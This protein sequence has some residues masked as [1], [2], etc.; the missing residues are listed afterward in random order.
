MDFTINRNKNYISFLANGK[1][2]P[3][4][5]D[6]NTGILYSMQSKPLK[7]LPPKFK[8]CV[9]QY[10]E[11]NNIVFTL[12]DRIIQE[13]YNYGDDWS[14]NMS[15]FTNHAELF[16]IA[17][18]LN[19]L[20]YVSK[21]RGDTNKNNLIIVN[22]N[23]KAFA[24]YFN[25]NKK[26]SIVNFVNEVYPL[27]WAKKH[28]IEENEIFTLDVIKNLIKS[29]FTEEQINYIVHC[30]C[31]GVCYY[32]IRDDGCL[33]YWTMIDKFKKYFYM[34]AQMDLPYEK[35]F[36][37]SYINANRMYQIHK[38][39]LDNKAIIDN[40]EN[41]NLLFEDENFT[42]VI[43]QTV[44]DF[45]NEATQ[46]SNCVYS[47]YLREV[48]NHKTNIVFIRRKDNIEKSYITCEVSN[49]GNIKQYLLKHNQRVSANTLE[50]EFYYKYAEWLK[51]NWV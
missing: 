22:E 31:R 16:K 34:C 49:N 14:F 9:H 23:F 21:Y 40:Y 32:F 26:N 24:K 38:M 36:F 7:R 25:D 8:T 20:G 44:E 45:K 39:Q 1:N 47:C 48:V 41:R 3:Y 5:F 12:M 11:T 35:D 43:P 19:S 17:D 29:H 13:P 2:K 6:I 42:I 18:K 46:Q 15:L 50:R 37:R 4:L 51:E 33:E 10:S 27:I 30:M 28:N